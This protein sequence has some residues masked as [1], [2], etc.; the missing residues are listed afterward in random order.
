MDQ[1]ATSTKQVKTTNLCNACRL[2]KRSKGLFGAS[3][4]I[5]CMGFTPMVITDGPLKT[6]SKIGFKHFLTYLFQS[7]MLSSMSSKMLL[8][9]MDKIMCFKSAKQ[10]TKIINLIQRKLSRSAII[11]SKWSIKM[12]ATFSTSKGNRQQTLAQWL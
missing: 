2:V 10:W 1:N 4:T 6:D 8:F 11:S 3:T 9:C 7:S 12:A 5:I